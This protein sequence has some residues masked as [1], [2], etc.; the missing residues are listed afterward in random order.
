VLVPEEVIQPTLLFGRHRRAV[1]D[2]WLA[3]GRTEQNEAGQDRCGEHRRAQDEQ[4]AAA[5]AAGQPH[6]RADAEDTAHGRE[7]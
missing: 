5:P 7:E 6:G 2:E 4:Q 3:L 1:P